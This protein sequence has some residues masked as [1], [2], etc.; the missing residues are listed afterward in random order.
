MAAVRDGNR[1]ALDTLLRRHHD[2]LYTLC[3]RLTGNDADAA[4]ACQEALIAL[5]RGLA[6]FDGRAQFSTWAYRVTT[7]SCLDELRR[8]RRRP[9]PSDFAEDSFP[10]RSSASTPDLAEP[11]AER[12]DIDAALRSLPHDFR[13]A[14]VLRDQCGMAYN[15]IADTLGVPIGTVRSR[16]SRGRSILSGELGDSYQSADCPAPGEPATAPGTS[17]SS[18]GHPEPGAATTPDRQQMTHLRIPGGDI[19]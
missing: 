6:R 9:E 18:T 4:D 10:A 1:G 14:V 7:N 8:R 12:T 13:V 11:T 19:R 3:R 16:I 2:R 17:N 5:V 15:E